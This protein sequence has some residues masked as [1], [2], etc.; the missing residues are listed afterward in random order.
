MSSFSVLVDYLE[1]YLSG[2]VF[3]VLSRLVNFVMRE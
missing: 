1:L 2:R 3:C